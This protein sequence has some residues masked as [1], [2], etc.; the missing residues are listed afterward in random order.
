MKVLII[1][2]SD[3]RKE[4]IGGVGIY[5]KDLA[6]YL[7]DAGH[8]V[9]F[10]GKKHDG[11]IIDKLKF[12]Y[13]DANRKAGESNLRF[14]IGLFRS[15]RKVKAD[16]IHA[17]R[18]DWLVPFIFRKR[19]F[20]TLHGSHY[21][22][23]SLKKSW[24][25][26]RLYRILEYI[27]MR[28]A[29]RIITVSKE[30]FRDYPKFRKKMELIPVGIRPMKQV[31]KDAAKNKLKLKG[32]VVT[33]IGRL[34]PEKNIPMLMDA[35][36]P[37]TVLIVGNGRQEMYL[38]RYARDNKIK[39]KFLGSVEHSRIPQILA[40]T[41]VLGLTSLHE[42]LPTVI[43]E[44]FSCGVPA[45]STDVGDVRDLVVD[46]RTGYIV[47]ESNIKKRMAMALKNSKKFSKACMKKAEDYYWDSIGRRI[48]EVYG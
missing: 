46:G 38:K 16:I 36:G 3:P 30:N 26:S 37:A 31:S 44:A 6:A 17:Q 43:L 40:A 11:P 48:E 47:D 1:A 21:K 5:A 41:D 35:A 29:D 15:A 13:I 25:M 45:V 8:E 2:D 39:A 4:V 34:E 12:H 14:L 28:S 24:L 42:G 9:T 33:F 27:A 23:I 10:L 20:I 18:P 32:P 19:K 22:N 7:A